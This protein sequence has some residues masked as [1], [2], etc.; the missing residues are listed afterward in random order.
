MRIVQSNENEISGNRLLGNKFSGMFLYAS[1][2]NQIE[3]NNAS[4][5]N[6]NGISVFKIIRSTGIRCKKRHV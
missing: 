2:L 4:R 6:Q 3:G 1:D 5:N